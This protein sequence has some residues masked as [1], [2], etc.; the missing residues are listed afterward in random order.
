MTTST[1]APDQP[2]T[3]RPPLRRSATEKMAGG[4]CGGL[5]Q[6]TGVDTLL[7]RLGFVVLTIAGGA[8]VLTYLLLWVLMPPPEQPGAPVGPLD[9]W[10]GDLHTRLTGK[11]QTPPAA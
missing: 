8:G 1:P 3:A 10:I 2:T 7:W 9:R 5:A 4:V 6:H 11:G